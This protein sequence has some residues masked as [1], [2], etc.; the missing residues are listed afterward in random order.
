MSPSLKIAMDEHEVE[1]LV[2]DL[3]ERVLKVQTKSMAV[4]L[5]LL[6]LVY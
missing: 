6:T 3:V 1:K 2:W 4:M 5:Y